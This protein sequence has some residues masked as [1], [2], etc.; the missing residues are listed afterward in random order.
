MAKEVLVALGGWRKRGG[1][2]VA[3]CCSLL[4]F[5]VTATF[6]KGPVERAE[7][8]NVAMVQCFLAGIHVQGY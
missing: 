3:V 6:V 5:L 7:V 2:N 1:A 4:Q 8:G